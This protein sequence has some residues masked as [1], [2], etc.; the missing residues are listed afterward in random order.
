MVY[1]ILL[2]LFVWLFV[3][4]VHYGLRGV[5]LENKDGNKFIFCISSKWVRDD[6][7]NGVCGPCG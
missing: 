3:N 5:M 7:G 1:L 2:V 6:K 4:I